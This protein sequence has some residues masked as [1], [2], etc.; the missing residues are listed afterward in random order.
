MKI[1][2]GRENKMAEESVDVEYIYFHRYIRNIPSD[3]EVQRE[4]QLIEDRRT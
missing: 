3:T 1:G 2:K 4:Y